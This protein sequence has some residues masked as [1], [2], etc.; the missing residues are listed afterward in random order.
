MGYK[1]FLCCF[2]NVRWILTL[3]A[4]SSG[5]F[6]WCKSCTS[7]SVVSG[8]FWPFTRCLIRRL[9]LPN[10]EIRETWKAKRNFARKHDFMFLTFFL[11][12]RISWTASLSL[13]FLTSAIYI[14]HSTP[15]FG[16][17]DHIIGYYVYNQL[18]SWIQ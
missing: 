12:W 15:F 4:K 18:S 2:R 6:G 13:F 9:I 8:Y 16:Y 14:Y 11:E 17:Y 1:R 5:T 7:F 10:H 3:S